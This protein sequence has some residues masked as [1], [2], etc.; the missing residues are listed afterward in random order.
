MVENP[1]GKHSFD[2][3]DE[4]WYR[5]LKSNKEERKE[6]C[7]DALAVEGFVYFVFLVAGVVLAI[8][9]LCKGWI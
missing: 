7:E 9:A 8:I 4:S 3:L 5:Y 2:D 1:Y 6:M